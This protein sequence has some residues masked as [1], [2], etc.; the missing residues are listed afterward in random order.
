MAGWLAGAGH[1]F[2]RRSG[3]AGFLV[4]EGVGLGLGWWS[5]C[6]VGADG[7]GMDKLRAKRPCRV[8][9]TAGCTSSGAQQYASLSLAAAAAAAV[10]GRRRMQQLGRPS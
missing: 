10:Q 5:V 1:T 9:T 4:I 8:G 6:L 7:G 2:G 3:L